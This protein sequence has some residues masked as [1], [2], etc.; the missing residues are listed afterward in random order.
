MPGQNFA[1]EFGRCPFSVGPQKPSGQVKL[2]IDN[3]IPPPLDHGTPG[4]NRTQTL[5]LSLQQDKQ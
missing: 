3:L 1:A 2:K 5:D 4:P